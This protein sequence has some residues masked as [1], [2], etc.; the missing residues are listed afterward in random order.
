MNDG[1][2]AAVCNI[3]GQS[4]KFAFDRFSD[5]SGKPVHQ[6]CYE[7]KIIAAARKPPTPSDSDTQL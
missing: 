5:E 6:A 4:V 1:Q 7:N 3:C 2:I